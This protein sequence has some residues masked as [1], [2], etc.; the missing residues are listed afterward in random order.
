MAHINLLPWRE[1]LR[2]Q[3]QREFASIAGGS[4]LLMAL[5]IVYVHVMIN[6]QI[7][8]QIE[9]NNYL[10]SE[11]ALVERKIVEINELEKSKQQLIARMRVIEELQQNRPEIVRRFDALARIVPNGLHLKSLSQKGSVLTFNGQAQSNARVSS[12]MRRLDAAE[13]FSSPKL[14]VIKAEGS[15]VARSRAF[16]LDVN[17]VTA[18]K[19]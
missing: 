5:V 13:L 4:V 8:N 12:F 18:S 7:D 3:K 16:T 9:R 15:G 2:K 17:A 10:K 14:K 6:G 19:E 1:E 11:I